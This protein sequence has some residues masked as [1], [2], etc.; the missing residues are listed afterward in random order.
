MGAQKDSH[1]HH[2]PLGLHHHSVL[3]I[4]GVITV[5]TQIT[6]LSTSVGVI[7]ADMR[8]ALIVLSTA[9]RKGN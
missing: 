5:V 3:A 1:L 8:N 7:V 9:C 4:G 6:Q 2:Q